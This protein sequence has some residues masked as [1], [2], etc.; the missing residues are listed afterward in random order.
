MLVSGKISVSSGNAL[1]GKPGAAATWTVT[2]TGSIIDKG[3]ATGVFLGSYVGT[4]A[5]GSL[6]NS[7]YIYGANYGVFINGP[8]SVVNA[9]GKTIVGHQAQALQ[10]YAGVAT[11]VN[12]GVLLGG[13]IGV[14]E[15][16]GGRVTNST[17]G[18][19]SGPTGVRLA[20]AGTVTNFG[21]ITGSNT[22]GGAAVYFSQST[23]SGRLII[24][25]GSVINGR[26]KSFTPNSG[27]V[28]ELASGSSA[29][30]L[31]DFNGVAITNFT[32]L[33]FD[34]GAAWTVKGTTLASGLGT[35]AITGFS[36]NDTIDLTGFSAVSETFAGNALTLTNTASQHATLHIQGTFTSGSFQ[37]ASYG[38]TGTGITVICFS[39]GTLIDTPAGEVQVE[40]LKVGDL[41]ATAHNGPRPVKW[42]GKGKVLS[43]RGKRT[44]ATPVIVRRGALGEN[45]PHQDLRVTKAHSLYFDGVLIPVEFLV[46][47]RTII[48]DDRA[49]EVEIYHVE[50]ESHDVLIANGV[51]AESYRDD[52]NRWLFQNAH[53]GWDLPPQ[54]PYAPVVTGGAVVDAVW[55]R[56]LER[57]G[58][59]KMPPIT[60]DPDLHLI[61]DG[62][63]VEVCGQID[64]AWMFR[65]PG[66]PD[67][68]HIASRE[69]VPAELGL[70]RDPRSLGVA[71]RRV[72][73]RQ[74][75]R[76]ELIEAGDARLVDGFHEYEAL[77]DHR[78]TDGAATL[79]VE[80]FASFQGAVEILLTLAATTRYPDDKTAALRSA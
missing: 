58:P 79:P 75:T 71:L 51:P 77:E 36:D 63:R 80:L 73:V 68:V 4:I 32:A 20:A 8:A 15:Q 42:I 13:N 40:K 50:L 44:A 17:T 31:S 62:K 66:R 53:D 47:H 35:I 26:I 23:G 21:T 10:L 41:V 67:S 12:N 52:G 78:W 49:Q 1:Y 16:L 27:S 24:E 59:R 55:R 74:G 48:W 18:T 3:G 33:A 56:R 11:V 70:A 60:D 2:N 43:T 39:A 76:F 9:V 69:V 14:Y 7:G 22:A 30:T 19:I 37:L 65:L 28:I 29:G 5:G 64:Q 72:L 34:A 38:G 61:V 46:N 25:P 45:M 54:E 6:T 57:A